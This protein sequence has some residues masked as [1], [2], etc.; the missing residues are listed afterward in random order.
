MIVACLSNIISNF[1]LNSFTIGLITAFAGFFILW[2]FNKK[3]EPK[4]RN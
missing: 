4:K 1:G 2:M 3:L